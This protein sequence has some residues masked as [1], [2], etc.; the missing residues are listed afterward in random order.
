MAPRLEHSTR[1]FLVLLALAVSGL[2]VAAWR[3]PVQRAAVVPESLNRRIDVNAADAAT[4]CLLPGVG[5]DLAE[6]IVQERQRLGGFRRI[7]QLQNVRGIGPTTLEKL[8]PWVTVDGRT[9]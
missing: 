6:A 1:I 4:L 2:G 7:E 3:W 8:R 5:R 9:P